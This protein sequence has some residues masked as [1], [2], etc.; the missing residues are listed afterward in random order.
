MTARRRSTLV[1]SSLVGL[2]AT[3]GL[4]AYT[5]GHR[6]ETPADGDGG[7]AAATG[8]E[9]PT[10]A[11]IEGLRRGDVPTLAALAKRLETKPD[12]P[13]V[14]LAEA[15][16]DEWIEVVAALRN[17]YL[18]YSRPEG[19]AVV[20]EATERIFGRFAVEP[21]PAFWFK[22]LGP[23]RDLF[24]TG[25]NDPDADVRVAAL[26]SIGRLWNWYPGR[27]ISPAEETL[28]GEWKDSF[29]AIVVRKLADRDPKIRAAAVS[30]LAQTPIDSLA[31]P[32]V[33]YADD[34]QSGEVRHEVLLAFA[35]RSTLLTEDM[36]LKRLHDPEP[37]VPQLAELILRGR[38]L[39]KDHVTLGRLITSPKPEMRA[40]VIPL[41]QGHDDLDPIVWLLRL[42]HDADDLVRTK[43]V[44]AM[45]DKDSPDVR[46]RLR[47]MAAQDASEAV[48]AAAGRLVAQS[49]GRETTAALPPLPGSPSLT[50][51]AN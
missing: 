13:A 34:P 6:A 14:P 20:V 3:A 51:R 17:G 32:A 28:L 35:R 30:C 27:A 9:S 37:G 22:N 8:P 29:H 23:A 4:V 33:V 44:E 25:L 41:L 5:L 11:T 2:A 46:A 15:E 7:R 49:E 16:A 24:V 12:A 50:P 31:A 1:I 36:I 45:T 47:E 39:S 26:R 10:T 21:A 40:S 48:R 43:A 38:G 42:S 18:K 19:R